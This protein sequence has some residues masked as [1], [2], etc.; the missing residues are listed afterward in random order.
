[1][2][3]IAVKTVHVELLATQTLDGER[4]WK[5]SH[6]DNHINYVTPARLK[7]GQSIFNVGLFS[8]LANWVQMMMINT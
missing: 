7:I 6:G 8:L 3:M 1:M 4:K 5:T 2:G